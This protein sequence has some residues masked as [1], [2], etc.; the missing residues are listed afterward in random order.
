MKKKYADGGNINSAAPMPQATM[1]P[2]SNIPGGPVAQP[3]PMNLQPTVP[4]QQPM[5]ASPMNAYPPPPMPGMRAYKK[6]GAVKN[7]KKGGSVKSSASR[8][9]DGIATKGKTKGRFV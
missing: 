9:G 4:Q 6:G 3:N 1:A 8:R 5:P 7:F 2:T